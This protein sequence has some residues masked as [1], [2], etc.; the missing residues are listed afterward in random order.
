VPEAAGRRDTNG[1]EQFSSFIALWSLCEVGAIVMT[2]RRHK[3]THDLTCFVWKQEHVGC[4]VMDG[5][6]FFESCILK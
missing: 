1:A 2:E 6:I 5:V 3:W 4:A